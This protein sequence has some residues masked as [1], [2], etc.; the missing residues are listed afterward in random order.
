MCG[1]YL[2]NAATNC[3]KSVICIL[4]AITPPINAP[5]PATPPI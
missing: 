3:G 4:F 5:I 1:Q 2:W